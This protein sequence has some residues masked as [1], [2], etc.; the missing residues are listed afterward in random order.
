MLFSDWLKIM[1]AVSRPTWRVIVASRLCRSHD[2]ASASACNPGELVLE[3][4]HCFGSE[5]V[6]T[7]THQ[8]TRNI[9]LIV[10]VL[11]SLLITLIMADLPFFHL[12]NCGLRELFSSDVRCDPVDHIAQDE[13]TNLNV[14][15][16]ESSDVILEEQGDIDPDRNLF[17]QIQNECTYIGPEIWKEASFISKD[18]FNILELNVTSLPKHFD[19]FLEFIQPIIHRLHFIVLIETWFNSNN[20]DLYNF[21]GF[22]STHNFRTKKRGGGVSIYVK[23]NIFFTQ[24][25]HLNILNPDYE[26]LFIK[27]HKRYV[28]TSRDMVLGACYRPPSGNI[29]AFTNKIQKYVL[30]EAV[31]VLHNSKPV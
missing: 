12:D 28:N 15:L 22:K 25:R 10:W 14:E 13:L 4:H 11:Y 29:E 8:N 6:L 17:S 31:L 20:I 21:P 19:L 7:F 24:V 9:L 1:F 30:V 16:N 23:N 27:I 18:S 2:T 26:F 5:V 3:F